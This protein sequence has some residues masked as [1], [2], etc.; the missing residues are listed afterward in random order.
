MQMYSTAKTGMKQKEIWG[1][2]IKK[3][4][5]EVKS[6]FLMSRQ[7]SIMSFPK[8]THQ[9]KLSR[10]KFK[11]SMQSTVLWSPVGKPSQNR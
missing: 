2:K 3:E 8:R 1:K 9:D 10:A 11:G 4:K 7:T 5:K 6:N